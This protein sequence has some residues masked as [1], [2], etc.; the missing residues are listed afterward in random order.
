MKSKRKKPTTVD[1]I[2]VQIGIVF[3]YLKIVREIYSKGVE[4]YEKLFSELDLPPV[5]PHSDLDDKRKRHRFILSQTKVRLPEI[6]SIHKGSLLVTT[7]ALL[8]RSLKLICEKYA[9]NEL[10]WPKG[11][12]NDGLS[13]NDFWGNSFER[14]DK[15]LTKVVGIDL[16]RFFTLDALLIAKLRHSFAHNSGLIDKNTKV[17]IEK[18]IKR[19]PKYAEEVNFKKK[20]AKSYLI[21]LDD[22][23]IDRALIAAEEAFEEL[24]KEIRKYEIIKGKKN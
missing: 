7:Y 4:S 11:R 15:Y 2:R 9:K 1:L 24:V 10:N 19:V 13:L 8:E 14:A 5:L 22:S 6:N 23:F 16:P 17:E 3:R 20:L 12:I 18:I 21:I